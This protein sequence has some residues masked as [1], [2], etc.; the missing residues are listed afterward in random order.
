MRDGRSDVCS[1]SVGLLAPN[2]P[3]RGPVTHRLI[4]RGHELCHLAEHE[5][6]R[7]ELNPLHPDYKSGALTV[8]LLPDLDAE[9]L[10]VERPERFELPI[11]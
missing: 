8:E 2:G 10:R 7:R 5:S 11:T 6:G 9:R 3:R 4:E 1:A